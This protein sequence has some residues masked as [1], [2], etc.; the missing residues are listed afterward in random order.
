M[1]NAS[2]WTLMSLNRYIDVKR[3]LFDRRTNILRDRKRPITPSQRACAESAR[4]MTPLLTC[5]PLCHGREIRRKPAL[6][7]LGI[8]MRIPTSL[9]PLRLTFIESVPFVFLVFFVMYI[10]ILIHYVCN[11]HFHW[12]W[13]RKFAALKSYRLCHESSDDVTSLATRRSNVTKTFWKS[14][15]SEWIRMA[16]TRF[17]FEWFAGINCF[18]LR[19]QIPVLPLRWRVAVKLN[20]RP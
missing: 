10:D 1:A 17:V 3:F 18:I 11:A 4:S 8:I 5:I 14:V 16:I 6:L 2:E 9:W 20:L 19:S 12:L 7:I 15:L 13:R